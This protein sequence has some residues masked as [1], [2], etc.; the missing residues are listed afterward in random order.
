MKKE[1]IAPSIL[2]TRFTTCNIFCTSQVKQVFVDDVE[3]TIENDAD[4]LSRRHDVWDD[5]EEEEF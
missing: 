3:E 2:T 4:M 1:Y 5:E